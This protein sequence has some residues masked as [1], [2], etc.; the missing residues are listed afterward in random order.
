MEK[1]SNLQF[2]VFYTPKIL[3]RESNDNTWISSLTHS[4]VCGGVSKFD[5]TLANGIKIVRNSGKYSFVTEK[6]GRGFIVDHYCSF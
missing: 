4:I 3:Q 5:K 1:R 2:S 6:F